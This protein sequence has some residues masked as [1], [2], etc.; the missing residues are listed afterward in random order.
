MNS[1]WVNR[2][3]ANRHPDTQ[4]T[5]KDP[6]TGKGAC[7][8]VSAPEACGARCTLHAARCTRQGCPFPLTSHSLRRMSNPAWHLSAN[9]NLV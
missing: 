2:L 6:G 4:E 8:V 3:Q 5:F 7:W 9:G 1:L